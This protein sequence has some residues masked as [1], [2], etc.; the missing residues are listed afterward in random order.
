MTVLLLILLFQIAM[1]Y[2]VRPVKSVVWHNYLHMFLPHHR[3]R[4]AR[5]DILAT[6]KQNN[7]RRSIA[8]NLLSEVYDLSDFSNVCDHSINEMS[9]IL[10]SSSRSNI[11]I[12]QRDIKKYGIRYNIIEYDHRGSNERRTVIAIRGTK[13]MK[14]IKLD[15]D[16]RLEYDVS[17]GIYVHKGFRSAYRAILD[18]IL[19]DHSSPLHDLLSS[20]K[21]STIFKQRS[22]HITGHSLGK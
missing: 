21:R 2:Q 20:K 6:S 15:L 19:F 14:N 3:P 4:A 22:L 17:L 13:N 18:D 12:T 8:D 1:S 7:M 5:F 11:R 16:G 9:R 10:S